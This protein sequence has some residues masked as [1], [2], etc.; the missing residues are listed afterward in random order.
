MAPALITDGNATVTA[1]DIT[2]IMAA[3]RTESYV[4]RIAEDLFDRAIILDDFPVPLSPMI[5]VQTWVK[6]PALP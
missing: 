4:F 2:D 1:D 6:L 5:R 3:L